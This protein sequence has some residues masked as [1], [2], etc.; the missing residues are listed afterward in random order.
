M[1]PIIK[2][3]LTG[4]EIE[5]YSF[6]K[7]QIALVVAEILKILCWKNGQLFSNYPNVAGVNKGALDSRSKNVRWHPYRR[8]RFTATVAISGCYSH[9]TN[10][11][12]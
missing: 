10:E 12:S 11:A 9:A 3:I 4:K 6:Y 8:I 7:M 5:T 2:T 1:N